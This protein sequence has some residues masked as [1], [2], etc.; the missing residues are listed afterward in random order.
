MTTIAGGNGAGTRDG[1]AETA[2]FDGPSDVAIE[3]QGGIYVAESWGNRIRK[4]TVEGMVTTIA[5]GD[6][7]EEGPWLS[8]DGPADEA[9]FLGPHR[10]VLSPDGDL[11]IIQQYQIRRLS[12]SGW[13]TTVAGN[14][15][16][17]WKDGPREYAEFASLQDIDVDAEGNVY[18]LDENPYVP[19]R[20]G[21][22]SLVRKID[23]SGQVSTL[24]R[25][26]PPNLGGQ[27]AG[28]RGMGVTPAGE[29]YLAN[30][31]RHQIV[32]VLGFNQLL[33]VAG[34]GEVGYLDGPSGEA[35]FNGPGALALSPRGALVVMDQADSV[36]RVVLPEADG[37]FSGTT[38]AELLIPRLEGVRV[39]IFAGS[40][41]SGFA[42]GPAGEALFS[43]PGGLALTAD[44]SVIVADTDNHAIRRISPAGVVSTLAGGNGSGRRDEPPHEA[45]FSYPKAVVVGGDGTIYVTDTGNGLIRRLPP[46]GAVETVESGRVTFSDPHGLALDA[47]GN[48]LFHE[49]TTHGWQLLRLSP[50]GELS[51]V[52]DQP[53][54]LS[55]AFV[56]DEAGI[57][58]FATHENQRTSIHKAAG[59][60]TASMVFEDIP[61][62]YGGVFSW[63]VSAMALAPDGTLY[64]AD[65][66][67]GRVVMITPDGQATIVA[68]RDSVN[69]PDFQP[70]AMLITLGG[71][72]LVADAYTNVIWKI[73]LPGDDDK[74]ARDVG[75]LF[76]QIVD[77]LRRV[78]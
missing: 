77:S 16:L 27:L 40:G 53:T 30:T 38:L 35:T 50:T 57:L 43:S 63:Y 59:D 32:K 1:P 65:R 7:P 78:P 31:G 52:L 36:V 74:S 41:H 70:V 26:Y 68:D 47:A 73:T 76:D 20:K 44:G 55:D 45:Q 6:Q 10:V 33:A 22:H 56:L 42:D 13:V 5:G 3:P 62:T 28:S 15:G 48:L 39:A 24:F 11:Y 64:A 2:Q 25:G 37:S 12:P 61:T 71:E 4:I 34:T 29:I 69:Y 18:V 23:T 9:L 8:R 51:D 21:T 60:G 49:S 72:L 66:K 75:A 17:G 14:G 58:F 19:D 46:G 67:Y 54:V